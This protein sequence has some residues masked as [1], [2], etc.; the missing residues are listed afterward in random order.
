LKETIE[1]H[2]RD[3]NELMSIEKNKSQLEKRIKEREVFLR[4]ISSNKRA[5]SAGIHT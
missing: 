3:L 1:Q 2:Q 4:S 5:I